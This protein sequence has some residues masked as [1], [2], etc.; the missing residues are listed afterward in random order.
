MTSFPLSVFSTD[1]NITC[2]INH[3]LFRRAI[4]AFVGVVIGVV[5][6]YCALC[7][8]RGP[9]VNVNQENNRSRDSSFDV[10][11]CCHYK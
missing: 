4:K 10:L 1:F 6:R 8:T 7:H 5:Q 3:R 11:V 9:D 2:V